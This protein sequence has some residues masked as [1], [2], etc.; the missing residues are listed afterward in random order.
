MNENYCV[1]SCPF[2]S[3]LHKS[4]VYL[5]PKIKEEKALAHNRQVKRRS[6]WIS[7]IGWIDTQNDFN[8]WQHHFVKGKK[9]NQKKLSL[10]FM[11]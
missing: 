3:D 6:D 9:Q 8:V 2:I 5:M 10:M 4:K 7:N 1:K 11:I